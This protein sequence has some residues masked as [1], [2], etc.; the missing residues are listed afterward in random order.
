MEKGISESALPDPDSKWPS[1]LS[2][3]FLEHQLKSAS[4][5]GLRGLRVI[6]H[7]NPDYSI[8]SLEKLNHVICQT[9]EQFKKEIRAH[10]ENEGRL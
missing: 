5:L 8:E 3:R 1:K 7:V 9:P 2:R 6:Y 4:E 10:A